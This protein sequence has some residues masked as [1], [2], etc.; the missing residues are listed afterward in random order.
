MQNNIS[1]YACPFVDMLQGYSVEI[2][3]LRRLEREFDRH[4]LECILRSVEISNS[5][6]YPQAI[7]DYQLRIH[8]TM[9]WLSKKMQSSYF[10][11]ALIDN[12]VV[13]TGSLDDNEITTVFVHPDHQQRGIGRT[14]MGELERYAKSQDI[15]EVILNSSIT[16][17]GFYKKLDYALVEE[18]TRGY[19]GDKLITYLMKKRL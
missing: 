15:R 10:V 11:V 9:D 8:Y 13:G 12:K 16:A 5:P 18:T 19:Q 6:D 1:I 4:A 14:I 3:E 7:I 2:V 17:F